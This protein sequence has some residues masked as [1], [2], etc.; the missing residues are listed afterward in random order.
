MEKKKRK[1]KKNPGKKR[2]SF[3]ATSSLNKEAIL[4]S[5]SFRDAA[6]KAESYAKNP[7]KLRQLYEDAN[8][9]SKKISKG[10]FAETWAYLMAMLRLIRAYYTGTYSDIP[11]QSLVLIVL[12][13]I[14]FVSPFDLIPDWLPAI[15]LIDDALVVG[16]V[17]KSVKDDLDAFMEW[18]NRPIQ[19]DK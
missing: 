3:D 12:T 6:S 10:A 13:V 16:I 4:E 14:Y 19:D 7:D 18:E 9:K 15:G 1:K 11:W 17:L 5:A 2:Q 8:K